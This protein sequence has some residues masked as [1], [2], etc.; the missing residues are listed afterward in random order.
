MTMGQRLLAIADQ[1]LV[2]MRVGTDDRKVLD[3]WRIGDFVHGGT[4]FD[5][6][7]E[8][9]G[10][11]GRALV[12]VMREPHPFGQ[13]VQAG[14]LSENPDRLANQNSIWCRS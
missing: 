6:V 3:L 12:T 14:Q 11:F 7:A 2:Q 13:E 1:Q 5:V 9:F 4:E 8:E 10:K